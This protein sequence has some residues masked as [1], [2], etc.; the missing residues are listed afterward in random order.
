MRPR[1]FTAV[2][3]LWF[4]ENLP[5]SSAKRRRRSGEVSG[6]R[7]KMRRRGLLFN[8]GGASVVGSSEL[9]MDLA[10][11]PV[12][13]RRCRASLL[14]G[15]PPIIN[16]VRF[17]RGAPQV[18]GPATRTSESSQPGLSTYHWTQH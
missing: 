12:E 8:G 3:G 14:L 4:N 10:R 6:G 17:H 16:Q 11:F 18:T 7:H 13:R 2:E 15:S 1:L 5:C 9:E